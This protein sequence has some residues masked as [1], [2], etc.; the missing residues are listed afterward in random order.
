[1]SRLIYPLA[2]AALLFPLLNCGSSPHNPSESYYLVATN[3]KL[4]YWQQAVAGLNKAATEMQVKAELVGPDSYDPKA[5]H[6][7]FA[8]VMGKKPTGILI[9]VADPSIMKPD[10]ENA[11]SQGVAVITIDSDA[12]ESKRLMF[13]GTDNYKAGET[14]AKVVV[15]KLKGKG[16]VVIYTMPEQAN[17]NE[18]LHG[19]KDVFANSPGI[20]V[21]ETVDMKGDARVAFDKT[22]EM[23]DKG[24]K[25]DAYVCLEAIACPEV[26]E[27]LDRKK[28][29]GKV[30]VGMDTDQR[31]LEAIQKGQ[32]TATIGQK[33]YT[34]AFIGVRML[35]D[36]HH[37][38]LK[39]LTKNWSTDSFSPIPSLI[40]TGAT[41]IDKGNVEEFIRDRNTATQK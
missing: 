21:V 28:V 41:L 3:V 6:D 7:E 34:M 10:I 31:T 2:L 14:G 22:T 27:V 8:K 32:I 13:V 20:K 25:A 29:S 33:P 19:Y 37:H 16:N 30:V 39:S 15:E 1:M 11:I 24:T 23:I 12:P 9:S 40:D 36:L 26:A 38:P 5:Q 17:L 18:R 4:P 35:D